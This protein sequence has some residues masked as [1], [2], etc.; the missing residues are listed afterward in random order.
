[1]LLLTHGGRVVMSISLIKRR[2][3][4]SDPDRGRRKSIPQTANYPSPT[5]KTA[6]KAAFII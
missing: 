3:N 5:E 6:G 4:T 1:M 2:G